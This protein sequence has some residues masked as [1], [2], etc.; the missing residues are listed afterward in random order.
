MTSTPHPRIMIVEDDKAMRLSLIDLLEAA[1]WQ[2]EALPR[3]ARVAERLAEFQP[4]VILSDVRMPGLSGLDLLASLDPELSPPLVLISAHGD[5]ATA[6][7][8]MQGGAYSFVEKPYEPRRLLNIL[9]HALDQHRMKRTTQRLKQRLM[10]LSGLDRVLLGQTPETMALREEVLD[11]AQSGAAVLLQGETG[12]GKELV[13]RALHDLGPNAEGPF[14]A[15]NCAALSPDGF[16]AEMFGVHD[17]AK[18]RLPGVDGGTI[19]LDEV[20]SCPLAVQA[21][22]LRVIEDKEVLPLGGDRPVPLTFRV[23]SATNEDPDEAVTDGRLRQ[24]LLYRLNTTVI[25]PPTLRQRRDDV[26]L[27]AARF[28]DEFA[29]VYETRAPDITPEDTAA[30]LA[31]AWPGNV[32]ELRNVCERRVLAARRGA[33]SMAQALRA[34]PLSD[35]VPDTL[36]EAVAAF[37][38][39]L[40]SKAIT[41]H[42]GRMEAVA[43]ALGIGRRTLN[44]KIVKLG[45]DKEALL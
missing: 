27:L 23:I 20:C 32:R 28:L 41:A 33:G 17:G 37:E 13:A 43:E 12:T 16:E 21:K 9:Q 38:R 35:D 29:R 44:E 40:I 42:Q 15:L 8:A 14:L 7:K 11:L 30:L 26:M 18:G 2:V 19:F 3:A 31:H 24:D 45:L 1:G 34:D 22:L 6:V 5:I 36:R 25:K 39:E 4:D 10:Q